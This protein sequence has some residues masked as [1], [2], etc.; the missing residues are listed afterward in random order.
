MVEA[1]D[2]LLE[3]YEMLGESIPQ[4]EQ[5]E[6]IFR[7]DSFMR[8]VLELFYVDVLDFHRHALK[9]FNRRG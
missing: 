7:N 4:F 5:Y 1:F 3:A 2:K 9:V 8:K 6:S